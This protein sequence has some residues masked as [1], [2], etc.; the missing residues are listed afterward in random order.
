MLEL[1]PNCECCDKDLP[2]KAREAM[3]CTFEC[4]FCADCAEHV[5]GGACPN[6]GGEFSRAAGAPGRRSS[7]NIRPRPGACCATATA[8][9]CA[10]AHDQRYRKHR[11]G[12]SMNVPMIKHAA[13][14]AILLLVAAMPAEAHVGAGTTVVLHG[15][16]HAPAVRAGSHDGDDRGRAVGGAQGRQGDLGMAAR[17]RRR[18]AGRRRARHA[19]GAAALRRTGDPR[20]GRG[21]RPAGR[22]GGRICRFR[23][24][25]RSIGLF[26][27]FH[28]HAHGT[29]VAGKCRRP[30]IH[31]RLR[32]RHRAAARRR[33]RCR[34]R[35]RPASS[36]AWRGPPARPARRSASASPSA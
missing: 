12:P 26:A 25:S 16:L 29:E 22:A 1:R 35:L 4:T 21:A 7:T 3:I 31:G 13:L 17:L 8:R 28:G 6:C 9:R 19:A 14:S 36:A 2:P 20:L 18:D 11:K 5:F 34:A 33:H 32:A 30:R 27:L 10:R 15:R 23:P 24:A